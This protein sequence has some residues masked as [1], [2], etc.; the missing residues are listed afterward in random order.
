MTDDERQRNIVAAY[1]VFEFVGGCTV[2]SAWVACSDLGDDDHCSFIE[3][4]LEHEPGC[5]PESTN[6]GYW[7]LFVA[8]G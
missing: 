8:T 2:C 4:A 6:R 1:R 7:V 3:G 5:D